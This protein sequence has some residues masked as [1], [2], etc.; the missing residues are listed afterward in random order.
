MY[1]ALYSSDSALSRHEGSFA[2]MGEVIRSVGIECENLIV[3]TKIDIRE[4]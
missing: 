2:R 3:E 1:A 4:L